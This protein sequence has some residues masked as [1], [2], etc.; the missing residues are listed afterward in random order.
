MCP[1]HP[2]SVNTLR[3]VQEPIRTDTHRAKWSFKESESLLLERATETS[4]RCEM[5][6]SQCELKQMESYGTPPHKAFFHRI[7]NVSPI[8]AP[9]PFFRS[10]V[11]SSIHNDGISEM[12]SCSPGSST[13]K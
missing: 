12:G 13:R 10:L 3:K 2:E 1:F 5:F 9:F 4:D 11:D 6:V 7:I 8:C